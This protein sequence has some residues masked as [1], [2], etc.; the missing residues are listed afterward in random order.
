[1]GGSRISLE[2]KNIEKGFG[3]IDNIE[4]TNHVAKKIDGR[5]VEIQ[6][7]ISGKVV[8][9]EIGEQFSDKVT[10]S[11]NP[12]KFQKQTPT[13][14]ND[15]QDLG[16]HEFG[17]C[18]YDNL[19]KDIVSDSKIIH[20]SAST[21]KVCV[22]DNGTNV[23]RGF[24]P[25]VANKK[26][27]SNGSSNNGPILGD[28]AHKRSDAISISFQAH[29]TSEPHDS[30]NVNTKCCSKVDGQVIGGIKVDVNGGCD[31]DSPKKKA[32]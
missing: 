22:S 11:E 8:A 4:E 6:E 24:C 15:K 23:P 9:V 10:A 7:Q 18:V 13:T 28:V 14:V 17:N 29:V 16:Q 21:E 31:V 20:K 3:I 2:F 27:F 30:L 1:M 19:S 26:P 5:Y 12:A 32:E 25:R